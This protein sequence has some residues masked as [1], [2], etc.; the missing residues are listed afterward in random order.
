MDTFIL[1]KFFL[2]L[3]QVLLDLVNKVSVVKTKVQSAHFLCVITQ[4]KIKGVENMT[5]S[6]LHLYI[7]MIR[8]AM[9]NTLN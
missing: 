3:L 9:M 1:E 2:L 7:S 5:F 8:F 4:H 6:Q